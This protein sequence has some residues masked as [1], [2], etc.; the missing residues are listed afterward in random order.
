MSEN[1]ILTPPL[2][3]FTALGKLPFC[4]FVLICEIEIMVVVR[5]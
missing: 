1:G 2:T 3:S 4:L 5:M